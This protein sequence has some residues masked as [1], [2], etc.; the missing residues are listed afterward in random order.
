M[1][2]EVTEVGPRVSSFEAGD[3]VAAI[4]NVLVSHQLL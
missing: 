2:G 4:L 3:K 1:T